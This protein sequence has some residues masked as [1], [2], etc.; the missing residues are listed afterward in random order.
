MFVQEIK[1][2]HMKMKLKNPFKTSFGT[3]QDKEFF[4]IEAIDAHGNSGFGET[5]AF[6]IPW[7]TE[8][9]VKTNHHV[10]NDFLIPLLRNQS[11]EHP[12]EVAELFRR[13][14]G[15][16][17]AKA[18]IECAIW[19]LYAKQQGL[20]LAEVLGGDKNA[21]DVG[22]SLGI[23]PSSQ[24]LLEMIDH[25]TSQGYKRVKIKIKP[26][27]DVDVLR[28][29][30]HHFP[31]LTLMAD[32]NGA[33]SSKDFNI[34]TKLD[35]FD[36]IMIEQPLAEHDLLGHAALQKSMKTPICLDESIHSLTDAQLAI[37]LGSCQIINIKI[38]RVGGITEAI[39][40][41]H[42]CRDHQVPVWCGGM[43]ESGIGRAYNI[44]I[45]S[46]PQ[47]TFPGDIGESS[48]YWY[49][50]I[51]DPEVSVHHGQIQIP[52]TPGIGYNINQKTFN[53]YRYH[54]E[55]FNLS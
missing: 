42:Y 46:L 32:A 45:A 8:E 15:N 22:I 5:V 19:D 7:Y 2:H 55:I 4:I 21:I 52:T 34:L 18:A 10:I 31:E 11:I 40:I 53:K 1:L 17:M 44:A 16:H 28:E 23:Q 30:R 54:T 20:P 50:D 9:T 13:V 43:L 38:G 27:H 35:E 49:E 48:H 39:N 3:I 51:I 33:Y 26:G 37:H 14:K 41:H 12:K 6:T 24:D 25:Y 29:V 47:F 36:L